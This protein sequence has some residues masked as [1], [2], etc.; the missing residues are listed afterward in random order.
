[1]RV[2]LSGLPFCGKST[3]FKALVGKE[4]QPKKAASGKVQLNIG[5]L[6]LKDQ[7]LDK[8]AQILGSEKVTHPKINLIDVAQVAEATAK[9]MD[10]T[11]IRDFDVLA[12]VLAVFSSKDPKQDLRDIE[13]DLILSDTQ[14]V[15][16]RVE[17][18]HKERKARPQKEED[19]E[20]LLVERCR[21]VLEKE[22]MLKTL[23]LKPDE[24]KMLAGF[25]FLTLKPM[26][27]MANVSEGQLNKEEFKDLEKAAQEKGMLFFSICAKLEAEIEELPEEERPEFLNSMGLA[28]LSG[29]GFIETC[30]QARD[31]I[32][33][34]TVVGKEAR[35]WP[36]GRGTQAVHAA[37][38]V[39][40]DME[41]GFIRAEVV[42]YKDFIECG[43]FTNA[44]EKGLLRL[45]GKEYIVQDGDI[46]NF[47]FSV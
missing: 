28:Q 14:L 3:V 6:E 17:R 4:V 26:V 40:T 12:L 7:R 35:A 10:T 42:N 24:L 27:L 13:S 34:F 19:Q 21:E 29:E 39:H 22:Q 44:K 5:T 16:N 25:Q 33:F 38:S 2:V 43:S 23:E 32:F 47:K 11:H 46:I 45:E 18:I 37:G 31:D 8:L 41:R 36:I 30:F 1:M 20:L 9:G 15:H